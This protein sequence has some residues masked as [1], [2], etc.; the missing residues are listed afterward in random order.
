MKKRVL[1]VERDIV[2][3]T[4]VLA[5]LSAEFDITVACSVDDALHLL[6]ENVFDC[7]VVALNVGRWYEGSRVLDARRARKLW[8]LPAIALCEIV[9]ADIFVSIQRI[10]AAPLPKKGLTTA[11]L[12]DVIRHPPLS[13]YCAGRGIVQV[14][15]RA[16]FTYAKAGSLALHYFLYVHAQTGSLTKTAKLLKMS[17]QCARDALYRQAPRMTEQL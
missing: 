11:L 16:G 15:Q 1:L 2:F 6:D 14:M 3:V 4:C 8:H 10:D 13:A 9:E 17:T 12:A 7:I 5:A